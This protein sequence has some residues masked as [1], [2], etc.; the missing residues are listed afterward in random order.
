MLVVACVGPTVCAEVVPAKFVGRLAAWRLGPKLDGS[1]KLERFRSAL[2]RC[3]PAAQPPSK[4][5]N[6]GAVQPRRLGGTS[7][8]TAALDKKP[9]DGGSPVAP[10]PFPRSPGLLTSRVTEFERP[11]PGRSGIRVGVVAR[12]WIRLH[13]FPARM[14][15]RKPSRRVPLPSVDGRE[16]RRASADA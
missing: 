14:L 11:E 3:R 10:L 7:R 15:A 9:M 12:R 2:E 13:V 6:R 8:S 1:T 16:A 4:R 5:F